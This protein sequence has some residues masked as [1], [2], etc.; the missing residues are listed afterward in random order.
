MKAL[1]LTVMVAVIQSSPVQAL[2]TDDMHL[3]K[4]GL[5][6][7]YF[8]YKEPGLMEEKG[9]LYGV[10]GE[11]RYCFK[12][13]GWFVPDT[14]ILD[15]NIK[16][17]EVD[18]SNYQGRGK[19]G[20]DD[21]IAEIRMVV[22]KRY[23]LTHDAFVTPYV[24][25]G[26][27]YL[28][29]AFDENIKASGRYGYERESH[30]WYVPL[31]IKFRAD[32]SSGWSIGTTAEYGFFLGGYQKSHLSDAG[33]GHPDIKNDQ[34]KGY[35]ARGSVE[36][37]KKMHSFSFLLESY[38]RWWSIDESSS[39]FFNQGFFLEPTN[40]SLELGMRVGIEF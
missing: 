19:D 38:A 15:G 22:G 17:G 8:N 35:G 16:M 40:E 32:F 21:F 34:D 36:F 27:R 20:I 11:Y 6:A 37:L 26:F 2:N 25:I 1:L 10:F 14:V 12:G 9:D 4:F 7:G 3:F 13:E 18:Y 29:D 23:Q 31:G 28:N 30:Y 24:G 39:V 33:F 5:E